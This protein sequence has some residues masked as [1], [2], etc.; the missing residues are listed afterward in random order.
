VRLGNCKAKYDTVAV[1]ELSPIGWMTEG[2]I[3]GVEN[4]TFHIY[5]PASVIDCKFTFFFCFQAKEELR[6]TVS[7]EELARDWGSY[8][9]GLRHV[10]HFEQPSQQESA[11]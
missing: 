1:L 11:R 8:G 7:A 9:F 10:P 4:F 6:A 3:R 2:G 5:S